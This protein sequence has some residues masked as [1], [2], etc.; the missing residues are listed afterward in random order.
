MQIS[1]SRRRPPSWRP[2]GT[3]RKVKEWNL[4]VIKPVLIVC[5]SNLSRMPSFRD[6]I[7]QIDSFP[8]TKLYHI[9]E[10]LKKLQ[11]HQQVRELVLSVGLNNC[12]EW[13][14]TKTIEKQLS[15][16]TSIARQVFPNTTIRFPI[17]NFS[18]LL[19]K[20]QQ[21]RLTM[22]NNLITSNF[23]SE[24]NPL[25]FAVNEKDRIHRQLKK[26]LNIG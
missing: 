13:L 7:I 18:T 10:V 15:L 14:L 3:N 24:I 8:G 2:P 6:D 21:Q 17:I 16:L 19:D 22:F 4:S 26:N 12:L 20:D 11:P 1:E 25:F 9:Y 23:L 5:D